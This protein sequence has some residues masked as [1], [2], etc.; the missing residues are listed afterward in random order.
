LFIKNL[1]KGTNIGISDNF[2]KEVDEIR[3]LYPILKAAKRE[4]K[5][6]YFKVE[7][8][9][10]NGFLYRGPEAALFPLCGCLMSG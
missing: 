4:K 8:L 7:K 5:E 6:A 10:I 9:L 1:P 2:P 3:K